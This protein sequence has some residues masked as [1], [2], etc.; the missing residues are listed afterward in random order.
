MEN[1]QPIQPMQ[2]NQ[3]GS[4]YQEMGIQIEKYSSTEWGDKLEQF[5][6]LS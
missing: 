4:L 5:D 6:W 2:M 1:L 3:V